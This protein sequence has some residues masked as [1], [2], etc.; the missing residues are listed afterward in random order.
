M[1]GRGKFEAERIVLSAHTG[2]GFARTKRLRPADHYLK[3]PRPTTSP[4]SEVVGMM[5]R[6][7]KSG[8]SISVRRIPEKERK[9]YGRNDP[10]LS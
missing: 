6:M 4:P 8:L 10:R 2:E 9:K 5:T 3:P 7:Q 1:R